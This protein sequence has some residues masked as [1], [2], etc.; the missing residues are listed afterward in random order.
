M[1]V[2]GK[3]AFVFMTEILRHKM[4]GQPVTTFYGIGQTVR[5]M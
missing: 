5:N 3:S 1:Y 2:Q 4:A